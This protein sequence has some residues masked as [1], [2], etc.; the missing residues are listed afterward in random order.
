[1]FC[2]SLFVLLYFF[3]WPFFFDIL[4]LIAPLVSSNSSY[5]FLLHHFQEYVFP[6]PMVGVVVKSSA[7]SQHKVLVSSD[8]IIFIE[9]HICNFNFTGSGAVACKPAPN[10]PQAII[11]EV[12]LTSF[13]I[14]SQFSE[15][16]KIFSVIPWWQKCLIIV[17]FENSTVCK[18]LAF[19]TQIVDWSFSFTK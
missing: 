3:F 15:W 5:N 12:M 19:N 8:F 10:A 9:Q 1:M 6:L 2:W 4:I 11:I 14:Q 16:S 7:L 13:E 18:V 17:N